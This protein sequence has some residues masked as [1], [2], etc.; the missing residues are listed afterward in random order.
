MNS[1]LWVI[2]ARSHLPEFV[3]NQGHTIGELF[4]QPGH[5]FNLLTH[6]CRDDR[7]SLRY[8]EV[9]FVVSWHHNLSS[10][11]SIGN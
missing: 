8:P 2:Q 10:T 11:T 5:R 3:P 4:Y 1:Y 7:L 6:G 9:D